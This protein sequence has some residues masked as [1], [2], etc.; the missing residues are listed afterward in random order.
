MKNLSKCSILAC[1]MIYISGCAGIQ[2]HW[3]ATG[4][5][6]PADAVSDFSVGEVTFNDDGT[7]EATM[8]YDGKERKSTGT[9]TYTCNRLTLKPDDGAAERQ[10]D[11]K[12]LLGNKL[13]IEYERENQRDIHVEMKRV[14][15]AKD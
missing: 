13:D 7:Y 11:A 5:V 9:Y 2:G 12:L 1:G 15:R 3:E 8:T 6:R 14:G 10:Y 4:V